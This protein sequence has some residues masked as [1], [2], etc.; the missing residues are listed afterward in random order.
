M[1][2]SDSELIRGVKSGNNAALDQLI[3]RWYPQV[4]RYIFK[5]VAHEQDAYDLTQDVFVAML[6]N[7]YAFY[8]WKKFQA[9]L[10]TIAHNKC[11]DYFR[12][13]KRVTSSDAIEW[14]KPDSSPLPDDIV[15]VSV[16]VEKALAQ[17]SA[18]QREAVLLHYFYQF[19]AKEISRM[20]HTPLPTV[21]SRLSS[22]K[23][24]L[25]KSLREDFI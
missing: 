25:S 23:R 6:Q 7:I 24:L 15:T 17:L 1:E 19:T 10:F 5:I 22:A 13:R 16:T 20:T 2:Y 21:K 4:Y 18:V 12:I 14:D 8:P 9:W 3:R 11:M